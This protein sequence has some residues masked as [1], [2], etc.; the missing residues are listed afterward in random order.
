MGG[1]GEG[2][3]KMVWRGRWVGRRRWVCARNGFEEGDGLG[4]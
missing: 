4:E 3:G 2:L 1:E